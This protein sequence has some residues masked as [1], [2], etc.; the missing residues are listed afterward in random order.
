MC[1]YYNIFERIK[2]EDDVTNFRTSQR[3]HP[4]FTGVRARWAGVRRMVWIGAAKSGATVSWGGREDYV[5]N[6]R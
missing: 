6:E 5:K 4:M 2:T 3:D 1:C